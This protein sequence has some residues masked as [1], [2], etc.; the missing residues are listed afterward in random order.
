MG[1]DRQ[2]L[3]VLRKRGVGQWVGVVGEEASG[4]LGMSSSQGALLLQ[5]CSCEQ[6]MGRA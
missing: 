5:G 4:K 3:D 6:A 1:W 2:V